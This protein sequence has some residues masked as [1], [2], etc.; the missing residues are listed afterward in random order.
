MQV[1]FRRLGP[2]EGE[3]DDDDERSAGELER[4]Q[5]PPVERAAP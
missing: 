2:I 1:Y 4:R 5:S 3:N